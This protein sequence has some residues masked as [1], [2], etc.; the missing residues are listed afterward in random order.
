MMR[1][2]YG[3]ILWSALIMSL[4]LTPLSAVI[5]RVYWDGLMDLGL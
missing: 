5:V 2:D 3:R 1:S 4:I